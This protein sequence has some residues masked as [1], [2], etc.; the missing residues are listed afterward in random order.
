VALRNIDTETVAEALLGIWSRV[1]VPEEIFTDRG[2]QFMSDVMEEI[3]RLMSIKHLS[4][5]PYHPACNG[6][7]ERFNGTLVHTLKK[8]CESHVK[9][10]DRYLP[11][12]LF[13]YREVPQA[14]LGFSPFE[15]LYYN[16]YVTAFS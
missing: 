12:V 11:A 14:S 4:T 6:L 8:L 7:V 15:M 9:D 2:S 10:W 5:T 13:A 3:N 1:G 16:Y